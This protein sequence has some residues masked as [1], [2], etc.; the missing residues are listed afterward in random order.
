MVADEV[1]EL[2][3]RTTQSTDT[4]RAL[5]SRLQE[6][7]KKAVAEMAM[8]RSQLKGSRALIE[9]A[10]VD[11]DKAGEAMLDIRH[12][13]DQIGGAM[14]EQESVAASV[15]RNVNDISSAA[16]QNFGQ[17]EALAADGKRL[18]V[19]MERFETLLKQFRV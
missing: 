8:S 11:I 3:R 16:Q 14:Y 17:I 5:S 19:L 4:I 18:Q 7:S 15:T 1:R 9:Q 6:G 12:T 2:A 13:A 10:S